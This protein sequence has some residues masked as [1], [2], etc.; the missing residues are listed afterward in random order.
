VKPFLVYNGL[1][2]GVLVGT[3]VVVAGVW[4][5]VAGHFDWFWA[6]VISLVVSGVVSFRLLNGPRLALAAR[7]DERAQKAASAF[8]ALRTGDDAEVDAE[9][10]AAAHEDDER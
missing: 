9:F 7:I 3:F 8:E 1:R 5:L 10:E 4:L 6:L 2:L